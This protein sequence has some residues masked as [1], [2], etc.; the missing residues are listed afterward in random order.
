MRD[1]GLIGVQ[2][3]A[4]RAG[5]DAGLAFSRHLCG[6][7]KSAVF[8]DFSESDEFGAFRRDW[9]STATAPGSRTVLFYDNNPLPA[10]GR[11]N[12]SA[13]CFSSDFQCRLTVP[14]RT[15]H[16]SQQPGRTIPARSARHI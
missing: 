10:L 14:R 11:V 5:D 9:N 15:S 4:M 1:D 16:E 13:I 6:E 2:A 8:E 3:D 12:R 7:C